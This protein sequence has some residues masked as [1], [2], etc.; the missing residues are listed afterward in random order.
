M[1]I[2]FAAPDRD[3]LLSKQ[4]NVLY[5]FYDLTVSKIPFRK[6]TWAYYLKMKKKRKKI[7]L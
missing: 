7:K 5:S 2:Y 6:K 1:R 3:E 4:G